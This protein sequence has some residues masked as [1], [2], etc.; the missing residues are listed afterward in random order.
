MSGMDERSETLPE[1]PWRTPARGGAGSRIPLTREAIVDAALDVLDREGIEGLSMRNVAER[2]GTG[3]A[4]L[5]WHVR[6]KEELLQLVFERATQ[7]VPLPEPDP[8]RWQEQLKELGREMRRVLKRHR[9]VARLSLGRIPAGP[10]IA[11]LTEWL[12]LLLRPAGIP[13]R[14]IALIGDLAGLYVG[15]HAFEESLG[16]ASPTGEDQSPQQIVEMLKEWTRS[17]P[18][19][20]FPITRSVAD[21]LFEADPD[22][23]FE[24]GMDV[25]V[26]GLATYATT[27]SGEPV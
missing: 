8:A 14:V 20:R 15:A 26:R 9:D 18:E 16:L 22:E 4:S 23:R 27:G 13:D 3:A 11:R 21:L 25:I 6:N 17:L 24:F 2:L 10:D 5:Y 12:F 19:E 7:E 1:P